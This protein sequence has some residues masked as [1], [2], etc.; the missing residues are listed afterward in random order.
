M[1]TSE[2]K[3]ALEENRTLIEEKKAMPEEKKALLEDKKVQMAADAEDTKKLTLNLNADTTI[4]VQ[5]V[6]YNM[7]ERQKDD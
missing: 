1:E 5:A 7:L 4:I 2:K 6:C 3:L